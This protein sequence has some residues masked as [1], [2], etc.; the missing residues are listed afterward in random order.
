[1]ELHAYQCQTGKSQ[2]LLVTEEVIKF[3]TI[4]ENSK[5][6]LGAGTS[7]NVSIVLYGETGDSGPR[8]LESTRTPFERNQ[9]GK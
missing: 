8:R 5:K 3:Q 4:K 6:F 2:Q 9:T 1:M 7:A